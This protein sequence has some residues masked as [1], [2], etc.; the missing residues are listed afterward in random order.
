MMVFGIIFR[1]EF[2][3]FVFHISFRINGNAHS[4]GLIE[5]MTDIR[6]YVN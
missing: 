4:N 3:V 2:F 1:V 6:K 5:I